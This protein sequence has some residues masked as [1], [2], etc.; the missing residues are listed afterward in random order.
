MY[1]GVAVYVG[2]N[3]Y[4]GAPPITLFAHT[5]KVALP[6]VGG[7]GGGGG[8]RGQYPSPP[9]LGLAYFCS[10]VISAYKHDLILSV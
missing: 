2:E 3:A 5:C 4:H 1:A 9:L 10:T 8:A 7:G 6:S